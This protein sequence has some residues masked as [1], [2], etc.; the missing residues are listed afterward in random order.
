MIRRMS[1][2]SRFNIFKFSE[3]LGLI[4]MK[5]IISKRDDFIMDALFNL[6]PVQRFECRIDTISF[7]DS[8]Y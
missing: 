2:A 6:E 1:G 7:R 4:S 5:K 8:M 3:V